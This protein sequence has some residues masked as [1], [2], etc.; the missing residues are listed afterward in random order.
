MESWITAAAGTGGSAVLA[1]FI[2]RWFATVWWPQQRADQKEALERQFASH[3][4]QISDI[5]ASHER[6][7]SQFAK[8][9]D[10]NTAAV[11]ESA[12]QA[13]R[14]GDIYLALAQGKAADLNHTLERQGVKT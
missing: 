9:I 6:Q 7:V 8:A 11:R 3:D 4:K 10:A 2:I 14:M 12:D 5:T 13:R 1:L